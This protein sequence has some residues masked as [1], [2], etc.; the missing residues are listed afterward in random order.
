[1]DWFLSEAPGASRCHLLTPVV[2]SSGADGGLTAAVTVAHWV[3]GAIQ[4]A[5]RPRQVGRP[6][7]ASP[8]AGA[9]ACGCSRGCCGRV[10]SERSVQKEVTGSRTGRASGVSQRR[11]ELPTRSSQGAECGP[12]AGAGRAQRPLHCQD[13]RGRRGARRGEPPSSVLLLL[14]SLSSGPRSPGA[15]DRSRAGVQRASRD[16]AAPVLQAQLWALSEWRRGWWHAEGRLVA[17]WGTRAA[18]W[19]PGRGAA[20][21]QAGG[22]LP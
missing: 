14:A 22:R 10:G 1:M 9:D 7:A 3:T 20:T 13:R 21:A 5:G 19:E 12:R 16:R 15:G 18:C 17:V 11:P 8:W 6:D 2:L 4:A